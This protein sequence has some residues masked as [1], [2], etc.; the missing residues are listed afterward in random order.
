MLP[1][2]VG[3]PLSLSLGSCSEMSFSYPLGFQAKNCHRQYQFCL[4]AFLPAQ[5][6]KWAKRI[7]ALISA[8]LAWALTWNS[9]VPLCF[10]FLGHE[11]RFSV[12]L[13]PFFLPDGITF[14]PDGISPPP[15]R[16]KTRPEETELT[17]YYTRLFDTCS[18]C[19]QLNLQVRGLYFGNE[20]P[21]SPRFFS[22]FL[23]AP[24]MGMGKSPAQK[25]S[26]CARCY[27]VYFMTSA[28]TSAPPPAA[29]YQPE[30]PAQQ[31]RQ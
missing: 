16:Y 3:A 6:C 24:S 19:A 1:N 27:R 14:W 25:Q 9:Q 12:P 29:I 7:A 11:M 18:G 17:V 8:M 31:H 26:M 22:F 10:D 23:A 15:P 21:F 20:M 28:T 4:T 2:Q 30:Q 5:G 13:S